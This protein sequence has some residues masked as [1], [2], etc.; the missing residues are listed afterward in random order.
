MFARRDAAV[1]VRILVGTV[2]CAIDP[3]VLI[4]A[5]CV[6]AAD[7]RGEARAIFPRKFNTFAKLICPSGSFS[8]FPSSHTERKIFRFS[9]SENQVYIRAIPL[10][11]GGTYRDRHDTWVWDAMDAMALL[12]ERCWSRR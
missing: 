8:E 6:A 1:R 2:G 10:P 4:Q 7:V 3:V 9:R 12:D 5:I 11:S